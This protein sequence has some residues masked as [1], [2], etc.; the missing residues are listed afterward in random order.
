MK[1]A[2][3]TGITGQDGAY[4]AEFLLD[5]GYR[6]VGAYRRTSSTNFWRIEEL[7]IANHPQ[8]QLVE[9]D[10]NDMGSAIRLLDRH[11]VSEVYNLAAQSFVGVSFDQPVTT[12]QITGVG[13]LNLLEAIRVV[14]PTIRFY[15]AS[16][17]EMFGKVQAVPQN[18]ETPFHPRMWMACGACCRRMNR[19]PSFLL[20]NVQKQCAI[21]PAWRLL[22]PISI[23][24]G[25]VRE[26][27]SMASISKRARRGCA[28]TRASID[29][30]KSTC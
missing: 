11:Q 23:S 27:T 20:P 26:S 19:I 5:K 15:Q 10:L 22:R 3:I 8:L 13:A 14:D 4:L 1:V 18:E 16:T 29:R 21:S 17:S 25:R 2:L 9:F 24:R 30:P 7:G 28:S 12:A 6:V